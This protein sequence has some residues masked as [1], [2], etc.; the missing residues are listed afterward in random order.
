MATATAMAVIVRTT[1]LS[2]ALV[3]HA[4]HLAA[5][6]TTIGWHLVA[7]IVIS[8]LPIIDLHRLVVYFSRNSTRTDRVL[9]EGVASHWAVWTDLSTT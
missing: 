8:V 7:Q 9:N 5:V 4:V 3:L 2:I 6:I 1:R